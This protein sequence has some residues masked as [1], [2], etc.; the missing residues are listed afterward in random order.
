MFFGK[1]GSGKKQQHKSVVRAG[2]QNRHPEKAFAHSLKT[3]LDYVR[4]HL[5]QCSDLEIRPFGSPL[6]PDVTMSLVYISELVDEAKLNEYILRPLMSTLLQTEAR[7]DELVHVIHERVIEVGAAYITEDIEASM[8][9]LLDGYCLLLM[10][11]AASGLLINIGIKEGRQVSEPTTQTVLRGPQQSFNENLSTNI[12]LI[13]QIIKSPELKIENMEVGRQTR[14]QLA[15][16]YMQ[17]IAE[18]ST[19]E[20]VRK[21]IADIQVESVLESGYIEALIQDNV[22]SP[23]P[24]IMNSERPDAIAGGL[25]E[26][27]IAILVDGTPFVLLAPITLFQL[28][29][30]PEDY[31]NRFDI[32]SFLRLIRFTAFFISIMLPSL[33]I[34]VTTFHQEMLPTTLLITLAAQR[35]GIPFP[36]LVEAL[37]MELTFEV[38]REAGVR[39]PRAIGPA[40]SI[41]GALV[42]GQAAVDAGI[43]SA[44]MVMVV[45]FTAICN[46]VIPQFN[47]AISA[48]LIRFVFMLL[49]GVFGFMGIVAGFLAMLIHLAGIE[50]FGVPYMTPLAPFNLPSMKDNILRAPLRSLLKKNAQNVINRSSKQE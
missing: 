48:R 14:T 22:Y 8:L 25:L 12:H 3:N 35:E 43:V 34:A 46:F 45:S 5:R 18:M 11:E 37:L 27:Q 30:T 39:M 38:L 44:G 31:Y 26:G 7:S 32:A 19:I 36:G 49:A 13:R 50:S 23:F 40:I 28:F 17:G 4:E 47:V 1:S 21:R 42:L 33:Y 41:V 9:Q 16:L 2:G 20:K 24:T 6:A 15:I 10:Q 29:Q